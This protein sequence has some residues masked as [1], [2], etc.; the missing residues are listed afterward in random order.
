V[1]VPEQSSAPPRRDKT[2]LVVAEA[3]LKGEVEARHDVVIE[4]RIE[5]RLAAG[6]TVL[7]PEAGSLDAEVVADRIVIRGRAEGR[8]FARRSIEVAASAEV[9]ADLEAPEISLA[10]GARFSGTFHMPE[11]PSRG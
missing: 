5:G 2:L 8:L 7:V 6:G 1:V 9:R 3:I 4:G 11:A 10:D